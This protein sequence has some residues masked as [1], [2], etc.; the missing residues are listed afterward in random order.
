MP[1]Y[2]VGQR[3]VLGINRAVVRPA[4]R[5]VNETEDYVEVK[6]ETTGKKGYVE[7][8]PHGQ[9]WTEDVTKK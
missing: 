3:V 4:G 7:K 5:V 9:L 1:R 8:V 2:R 6:W